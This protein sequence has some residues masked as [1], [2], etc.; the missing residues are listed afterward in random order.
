VTQPGAL[1][2][3][4]L[5]LFR[6]F[7]DWRQM[8]RKVTRAWIQRRAKI[9]FE[10]LYNRE[11]GPD[12]QVSLLYKLWCYT[13]LAEALTFQFSNGWFKQFC[14]RWDIT[15]R[16]LTHQAQKLPC[17]YINYVNSFLRYIRRQCST[18]NTKYDIL[19]PHNCF[20][21]SQI[22]NMDEVP[23][24]F[25]FF[26]GYTY[27]L[28]GEHTVSGSVSNSS[29]SKRQATLVLYIF[30]DGEPR[31]KPKLIFHGVPGGLIDIKERPLWDARVTVEVNESAYNNEILFQKW[32]ETEL[33]QVLGGKEALLVMDH[34]SFH[35]TSNILSWLR[36]HLI[37]PA[38]IPPGCTGLLQPLDVAVNKPFKA[39]LREEMSEL[40]D[41]VEE[42][43]S[44]KSAVAARRIAVTK[45]VGEAWDRL[46]RQSRDLICNS[47]IHTGIAVTVSGNQDCM[48]RIKD[49]P[50]SAIDYTNWWLAEEPTHVKI[51][52]V[53]EQFSSLEAADEGNE[54]A[55]Q[56]RLY[57][58][59]TMKDVTKSRYKTSIRTKLKIL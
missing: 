29:W 59:A 18:L 11:T 53:D 28:K 55:R 34:A 10:L 46:C 49:I 58:A 16:R 14:Q 13:D 37:V 41:L 27:H 21:P 30:A 6:Q 56:T 43:P 38:L 26:D 40:I 19:T 48:I 25:E 45:A 9:L 31:L 54:L 39:I 23:I 32:L 57:E 8:G 15:L 47:F 33:K 7:V 20:R 1:E 36:D 17:E 51:E 42:D 52:A 2:E 50:A 12:R 24:P 44:N 3:L 22:L 5:E 35:K 4:E